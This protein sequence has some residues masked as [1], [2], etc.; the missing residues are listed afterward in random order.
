MPEKRTD[1]ELADALTEEALRVRK[2][3]GY[4]DFHVTNGLEAAARLRALDG[5]RIWVD[6]HAHDYVPH[7]IYADRDDAEAA[8]YEPATLILR[9]Q[10]P[11]K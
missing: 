7:E 5:E 8:G 4:D 2:I 1:A 6:V 3:L 11:V 10:E 9:P